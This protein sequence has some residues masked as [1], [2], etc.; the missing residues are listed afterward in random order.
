MR[1]KLIV[2]A[3]IFLALPALA[4]AADLGAVRFEN[5]GAPEAQ[6]PFQR[7]VAALH[8][9]F[10]D[11]AAD[12]FREAQVADP[13]FALAYWGEALTYDHPI[14]R[15]HDREA[16]QKALA[17]LAPTPEARAAKAGTELERA[18]LESVEIL[19]ADEGDSESRHYAYR[20]ALRR[21]HERWP[22]HPEA[23]AFYA[24][25]I[26][27]ADPRGD[28]VIPARM[29][30]AAVLEEVFPEFPEH[31]G[32][33]HYLIHAYDDPV[34]APLGLRPAR[35]YA[36]VAPS[37][38]HALHMPSHIFLQLGMWERVV[39]SNRDAVAASETWVARR[40]HPLHKVDLH[41]LSW[42]HYGLLQL[43]RVEEAEKTLQTA[44]RVAEETG[45]TRAVRTRDSMRARHGVELRSDRAPEVSD[46]S[47][48]LWSS[49]ALLSAWR[50][51][52][53]EALRE[54]SSRFETS[55]ESKDAEGA[56][57]WQ[58]RGLELLVDGKADA[59]VE[60]LREAAAIEEDMDPPSGP[61]EPQQPSHELLG[62]VLSSLGR[63]AEALEA[64]ETALER[65]PNRS[66][67]LHGAA[68]AEA[69]LGHAERAASY[70]DRLSETWRARFDP[71]ESP[72]ETEKAADR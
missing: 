61:P 37:A 27:G 25:A 48:A 18:F 24:L 30:S 68:R 10:Y 38:H 16:A 49:A 12:L 41:S 65:M 6:E 46:T 47:E 13:D 67:S 35:T 33:L 56:V 43:G 40:G 39:A 42:L 70:R 59:A 66:R 69:A 3:C 45:A 51:G 53:L 20:D 21:I 5:S 8:S 17:R 55:R 31:P 58:A 23:A 28:E 26:Q 14:W 50:R 9:F 62:D 11:E 63:H 54:L 15:E 52:D 36:E 19:F 34:H 72:M 1:H 22:N 29:R 7:G 32:I 60:A 44:D 2:F 4:S 64:Y 57:A 71:T